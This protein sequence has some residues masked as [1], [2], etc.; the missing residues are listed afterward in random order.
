MAAVVVP[1]RSRGRSRRRRRCRCRCRAGAGGE[2]ISDKIVELNESYVTH[3]T[4]CKS[5]MYKGAVSGG[6][7]GGGSAGEVVDA[8]ADG[9]GAGGDAILFGNPAVEGDRTSG[10]AHP[11]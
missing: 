5:K 7:G 8:A 3:T 2:M 6:G 10:S 1:E 11:L 9:Y 4:T